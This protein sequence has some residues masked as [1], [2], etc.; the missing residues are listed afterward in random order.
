M[1][2]AE[3][4]DKM[5]AAGLAV[6]REAMELYRPV[7]VVA[8][9]SGGNDS[10]VATHF[11]MTHIP[12]CVVFHADTLIGL[13]P[14]KQHAR[15]VPASYGWPVV[16]GQATPEGPPKKSRVNGRLMPFDPKSLPAGRWVDG[17]TYYEEFAL[18]FGFP[19]RNRPMHARMY[20]RLKGR[21][22]SRYLRSVGAKAGQNV[23]LISGVRSDESAIRA[24][25][26]R[27]HAL[28]T[29]NDAWVNPFY[30]FTASDFA[31]YRDEF[32]LPENPVKRRCGISGEC[33]CG[34]FGSAAERAAYKIVDPAFD[35]YLTRLEARVA[36]NG[37]PWGWGESPP[38]WWADAKR[39]QMFLFDPRG[40]NEPDAS[41]KPCV[42]QPMCVGCQAGRR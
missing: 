14:A 13:A 16:I 18:N 41:Y 25:Y 2:Q 15:T 33:C 19:G 36:D 3:R 39:K 40:E 1:D 32:G 20:Q 38:H 30:R 26:K 4:V 31:A 5:I 6:V 28:G 17:D 9:F 42:F 11:A 29:A 21:P 12:G 24:G 37:Y 22:I 34:T 7:A 10:I 8:A 27:A 35:A 23:M